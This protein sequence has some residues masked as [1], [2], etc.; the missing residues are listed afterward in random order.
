[1]RFYMELRTQSHRGGGRGRAG[2]ILKQAVCCKDKNEKFIAVARHDGH[3]PLQQHTST[4][5][6]VCSVSLTVR[7]GPKHP[8]AEHDRAGGSRQS[9]SQSS[10][11]VCLCPRRLASPCCFAHWWSTLY[12]CVLLHVTTSTTLQALYTARRKIGA[13]WLPRDRQNTT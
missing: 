12:V 9:S 4:V 13:H 8:D 3:P 2:V 6:A 11:Q 10:I 5:S 1:L 7:L